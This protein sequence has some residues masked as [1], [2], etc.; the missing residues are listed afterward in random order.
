[1]SDNFAF[2]APQFVDFTNEVLTEDENA[3]AYFGKNISIIFYYIL[4]YS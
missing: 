2:N 4:F 3:E 1:M